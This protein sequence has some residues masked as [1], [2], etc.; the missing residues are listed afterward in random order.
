MQASEPEI[1]SVSAQVDL[2]RFLASVC[3]MLKTLNVLFLCFMHHL[4]ASTA[5]LHMHGL[6]VEDMVHMANGMEKDLDAAEIFSGKG[7]IHA[8]VTAADHSCCTFDILDSKAENILRKEGLQRAVQI[9]GRAQQ[10]GLVWLAPPCSSFCGLCVSKSKRSR[11]R[12][13]GDVRRKFVKLG[14]QIASA[15]V[16]LFLVAVQLGCQVI[17]E[18]PMGNFFW[19]FRPVASLMK[20]LG[21]AIT[22]LDRCCFSTGPRYKKSF[23]LASNV[24][25]LPGL[26]RRCSGDHEHTSLVIK[27]RRPNG[28]FSYTGCKEKLVEAGAYPTRMAKSIVSMWLNHFQPAAGVAKKPAAAWKSLALDAS[29]CKKPS[30]SWKKLSLE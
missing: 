8:A 11:Q 5:V 1:C 17:M 21:L 23:A 26:G 14:N 4:P 20:S 18:N 13:A 27:K 29:P 15:A 6:T 7:R 16:M 2:A 30:C 22:V 9:I 24:T 10:G 12:P 25:W 28:T 3:A 19:S